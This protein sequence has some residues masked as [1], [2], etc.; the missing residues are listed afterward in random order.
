MSR[1]P[2]L[3]LQIALVIFVSCGCSCVNAPWCNQTPTRLSASPSLGEVM[4]VINS[5]TARVTSMSTNHATLRVSGAPTSLRANLY[6]ERRPGAPTRLRL[7]ASSSLTGPEMDLGSNDEL[8]W[9]W[10]KRSEPKAVYVARHDQYAGSPMHR[11]IPLTPEQL[12]SAL[13]LVTFPA[14]ASHQ[15][16][17]RAEPGRLEIRSVVT[18][19]QGPQTIITEVDDRAGWVLGQRLYDQAGKHLATVKMSDHQN[20]PISGATLPERVQISWPER[21]LSMSISANRYDINVPPT[22]ADVFALPHFEGYPRVDL[23]RS[24]VQPAPPLQH[25]PPPGPLGP[26]PQP[27]GNTSFRQAPLSLRSGWTNPGTPAGDPLPR[28]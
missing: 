7:R 18:G 8:F 24:N 17:F 12:V 26:S 4:G 5:D 9:V 15:G 2:L 28:R 16:P 25:R 13:G 10:V 21:G 22:V 23:A 3:T 19:P 1:P 20:D 6:V 11:L 14:D 27:A